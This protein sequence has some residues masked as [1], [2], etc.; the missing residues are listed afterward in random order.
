MFHFLPILDQNQSTNCLSPFS[1]DCVAG[2]LTRAGRMDCLPIRNCD[3]S[4]DVDWF[5]ALVE[6]SAYHIRANKRRDSWIV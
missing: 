5:L 3:V 2:S 4:V 6:L 1:P